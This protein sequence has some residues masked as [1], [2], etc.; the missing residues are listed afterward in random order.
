MNNKNICPDCG[1]QLTQEEIDLQEC[2]N[3]GWPQSDLP[4]EAE[5]DIDDDEAMPNLINR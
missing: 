4:G 3:C 2:W 5:W 1:A